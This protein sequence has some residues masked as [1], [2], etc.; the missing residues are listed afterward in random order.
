[1]KKFVVTLCILLAPMAA[2]AQEPLRAHENLD[3]AGSPDVAPE[4]PALLA[5]ILEQV[6]IPASEWKVGGRTPAWCSN[7]TNSYCTYA[8]DW[9]SRCCYATYTRPGALCETICE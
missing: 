7:R 1:M 5:L 6:V 4:S 3:P 2:V 8:W 9:M